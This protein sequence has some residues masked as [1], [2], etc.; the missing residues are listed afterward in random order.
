MISETAFVGPTSHLAF[1]FQD[2]NDDVENFERVVGCIVMAELL[3]PGYVHDA[4]AALWKAYQFALE[5]AEL[6]PLNEGRSV[7]LGVAVGGQDDLDW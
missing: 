6:P 4:I 3:P 2:R 1:S 7:S 5:D